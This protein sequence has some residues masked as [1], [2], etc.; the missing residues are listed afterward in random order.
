MSAL[1]KFAQWL[2][3]TTIPTELRGSWYVYPVVLSLHLVFIAIFGG[4]IFLTN[5]RLLGLGLRRYSIGD[6]INQLRWPKRI[7]FLLVF[8][9]G[10]L[11]A[12]SK[13]EEYY[14]NAFFWA[15][16][17]LLLLVF[18]HGLVFR[19]SLYRNTEALD[20]LPSTPGVVKLAAAL[21]LLLWTGVAI[22]GRGI[23]YIEP[24][25]DKLHAALFH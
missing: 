12:S 21:S 10:A 14:Y 11:L 8:T 4:M 25:V 15:K 18:V 5:L 19:S 22:C 23:G 1:L 7:G 20:K 16:M 24:P 9:C 6:V 2:Q 13:A 3:F 17:S